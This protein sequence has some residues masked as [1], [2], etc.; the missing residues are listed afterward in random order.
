MSSVSKHLI[1]FINNQ[2]MSKIDTFINTGFSIS[3]RNLIEQLFKH[4]FIANSEYLM[5]ES[6]IKSVQ[7]KGEQYS[8]DYYPKGYDF[9]YFPQQIRSE[10]ENMPKSSYI[11]TFHIKQREIQVAIIC[12][13]T[14]SKSFI[15]SCIK[16]IYIWLYMAS[17]FSSIKCSQKMNIY[18]YFTDLKKVLPNNGEIIKQENAN[19]AFTTSCKTVTELNLYREEEWF[20]VFIH[21]TFH[22]LGLDFSECDNNRTKHKILTLFPVNS[23]V[24]LFETY[25]ETWAEIINCMFISY[26]SIKKNNNVENLDKYIIDKMVKK[27]EKMIQYENMFSLFQCVKVLHFY[28]LT[29]MD[30]Y[31][32][33]NES[34]N[35]R[36]KRYKENTNVLS[37]YIL[38]SI[39]MFYSDDFINWCV[40]HNKNSIQFDKSPSNLNDYCEFIRE[41]YK[42]PQYKSALLV[43]ES[44][45]SKLNKTKYDKNILVLKSLRMTIFE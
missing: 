4:M 16:R 41:H 8:K 25:C 22:N 10:I 38:K 26:S 15:E 7:M 34:H 30:L 42:L 44:W 5:N 43:I 19:T 31:E 36:T 6:I 12:S 17:E 33:T 14:K 23:D 11:Y 20:K 3:S 37:Y 28:G 9:D 35:L 18:L 1:D 29:Y 32:K 27:T 40:V 24:N 13:K 2:Y 45:F 21:E 39:F